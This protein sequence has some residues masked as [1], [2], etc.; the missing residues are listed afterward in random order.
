MQIIDITQGTQAWHEF[1]KLGIGGSDA[2]VVEGISPYRTKRDLYFEK[3][4]KPIPKDPDQSKEFIFNMGHKTEAL[5]RKEFQE[6]TK[7]EMSPCCV[8][9]NEFDYIRASLDGFH[10]LLGVL[11]A[12]LVGQDVLENARNGRIPNHHYAQ[13]QHQLAVTGADIAQWFGHDGK[14]YGTLVT[15]RSNTDYQNKLLDLEHQFW[16]DVKNLKAP[17]LSEKDY[18]IPEDDTLL[19]ELRDA[20]ELAENA[21]AHFKSLKDKIIKKYK[22]PRISGGGLKLYKVARSGSLNVLS[23]PEISKI[24]EETKINLPPD[25]IEQ[26]R[27]KGSESWTVKVDK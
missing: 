17:P 4:G 22:H 7:I 19:K 16:D 24:V 20:K 18:L 8:V 11:E 2:P 5:I 12:K 14:E 10:S 9:H 27:T 25:Y 13:I 23:I 26:F 3:I 1:R 6:L 15:I 21:E